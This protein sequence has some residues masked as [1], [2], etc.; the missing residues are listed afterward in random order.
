MYR[1]RGRGHL[2][3]LNDTMAVVKSRREPIRTRGQWLTGFMNTWE[4]GFM[5]CDWEGVA[6]VLVG[7]GSWSTK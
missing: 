4:M 2:A 5:T 6:F 7:S 3:Q 1:L